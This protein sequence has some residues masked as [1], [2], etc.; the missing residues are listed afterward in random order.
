MEI[1]PVQYA[2][3]G[4]VHVAY[5]TMGSGGGVDIVLGLPY[6]SH[7]GVYCELPA[8][9]EFYR[10]LA[11]LGR[12]IVFDKRG[13]GMSDRMVQMPTL[14]ER[15]DDIRAVMDAVGS[16]R[17]ILVGIS[18]SA[19][20]SILFAATHPE[21]TLGLVII[22]GYAKDTRA[23]D[24]PWRGTDEE[25]LAWISTVER[26]W[27][28]REFASEFAAGVGASSK[29]KASTEK[30]FDRMFSFGASPGSAVAL[31]RMNGMIDVRSSL[32][33]IHVPTLVLA[34]ASGSARGT[35]QYLVN[36]IENAR[37]L[38]LPDVSHFFLVSE[39]ATSTILSAIRS[40]VDELPGVPETNRFLTTVMF[41]DIVG[42]TGK[43]AEM[44]DRA[45]SG[46]LGKFMDEARSELARF[47][48]QLVKTTGDGLLATF[49]GPT[50]AIRCAC[51]LRNRARGLGLNIRTGLHSGECVFKDRDVQGIAVHIASRVSATAGDG[52]VVVSRTVKDLSMGADLTFRERDPQTLKGLEGEW[53]TYSV[54]NS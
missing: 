44:G 7:L 19:P 6:V 1:P 17:A 8:A 15:M 43:V 41:T 37:L 32:S 40:F 23:P 3:S 22:G 38:V 30:W 48:G 46:L 11:A 5:Q 33:A 25:H 49:D 34:E 10:N 13:V 24:Y 28:T 53:Q 35:G 26:R 4:D 51:E 45:W 47:G 9:V 36:H 21:R 20:M 52:E 16:K 50:R 12:L 54:V 27:G 14:E 2:R 42:S 31:E 29:D 39:E 18:E